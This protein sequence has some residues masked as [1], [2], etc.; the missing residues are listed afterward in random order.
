MTPS[1]LLMVSTRV[2][3]SATRAIAAALAA[4]VIPMSV[5]SALDSPFFKWTGCGGTVFN[6]CL[7][8]ELT[9]VHVTLIPSDGPKDYIQMYVRNLGS[10]GSTSYASVF[11]ALGIRNAP[12]RLTG[13]AKIIGAGTGW[14]FS[15][16]INELKN[17][18]SGFQGV[19]INGNT[20]TPAGSSS[21][22]YFTFAA[23]D[24][25]PVTTCST[26][27]TG[28]KA[29][30]TCTTTYPGV[31]SG[32]TSGAPMEFA[33]HGQRGPND[34]S[35]KLDVKKIGLDTYSASHVDGPTGTTSGCG[36]P[37]HG[38]VP[39]PASLLLTATGLLGL[40][41]AGVVRR[42]AA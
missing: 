21:L 28:K 25:T 1:A 36:S 41:L 3:R 23:V 14:F 35:T 34:C 15:T 8:V 11:T 37:V 12:Y 40:G 4:T 20:G 13:L 26:S 9:K 31:P 42:R 22:F 6:T 2:R 16:G 19:N 39:E 33:L 10:Q 27:G 18:G 24:F 32:W 5:A 38:V 30:T 17:F 7:D 29:K